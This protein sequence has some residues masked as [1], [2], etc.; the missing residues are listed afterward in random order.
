MDPISA[1]LFNLIVGVVLSG[2][3]ALISAAFAPKPP[4]PTQRARGFRGQVQTGGKVPQS[5]L[6]GTIGSPGKLEY[7]NTWG[8][9]GETPNAYLVDVV[10]FGDLPIAGFTGLF[11]NGE[12]VSIPTTG[13]VT[14]G[15]PVA[16]KAGKLWWEFFDG[17]QTTANTYLTGKFGSDPDR[18]W[19]SDM[20][21]RGVPCLTLTALVD[22]AVW[23]GFPT[24]MGVFQ[25]IK[26]FDPRES[27][28]AGG[29]GSQVWG[30]PSTYTFSDNN[31]VIIYN[32]LRG[33]HDAD[34]NHVWGGHARESQLP[35]DVWAAAMDACDEAVDLAGGGSEKRYRAGREI[36]LD[37]R[38]A[39]VVAEL[40]TG[41]NA[42]IAMAG[43][44]FYIL[45]GVPESADFSFTDADVIVS[46]ETT[47]EPFPN[48]DQIVNGATASYIE[49]SQAWESKETAPYYRSDLE[50]EDDDRRRVVGLDL[51]T[52]FSGTQAQRVL[53]ATVE[54]SRRFVRHVVPLHPQFGQYRPLQVASWTSDANDYTAKLFLVTARTEAPNGNVVVGLQELDPTDFDWDETLDE[55]P[56]SFA[57]LTPI[58]PPAQ[59]M[60]GFAVSPYTFPG[61]AGEP[62]R[63]GILLE[64]TGAMP[65]IR[66]VLF[67]VREDFGDGNTVAQGEI[68]YD[69]DNASAAQPIGGIWTLGNTDY[70]VRAR[71]LPPDGS[72]RTTEWSAW[73]GVTT[74]DVG[75]VPADL[76]AS[77]RAFNDLMA[78]S[79]QNL[80]ETVQLISALGASQDA[81]N[82]SDRL[83]VL[84][85]IAL[86]TA[87]Y[88]KAILLAN[89]VDG[90][91]LADALEAVEA[92]SGDVTA[93]LLTRMTAFASPGGGWVRY[94]IQ[95]RAAFANSFPA[96]A[97][98]YWEVK[99][100]GTS[101]IVHQ[102]SEH[103]FLD[104]LGNVAAMFTG[105]GASF[106]TAYIKDLTADN[107]TAAKLD[108][109]EILQNG[110][111]I[112]ELIAANAVTKTFNGA[113]SSFT[114]ISNSPETTFFTLNVTPLGGEMVVSFTCL[115]KANTGAGTLN[116]ARVRVFRDSTLLKTID[117]I[118][119]SSGG[120]AVVSC[121]FV[122]ASPGTSAC[123]YTL[124]GLNN[125]VT[126]QTG[127]F[128]DSEMVLTNLLDR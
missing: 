124:R 4:E 120:T 3:S 6:V 87:A 89:G 119:I 22:E 57:P 72:G 128:G 62:R 42:R 54:E 36:F 118:F 127:N 25:G 40:L 109:A 63:P 65:D 121:S 107:I 45:V 21:G 56:L 68:T 73:L 117:G 103:Y 88:T 60:A 86:G 59:A 83:Y 24:Y 100:D 28:A 98:T 17:A 19:L 32:I 16:D 80:N 43:G 125:V 46:D 85:K 113:N 35:Y 76:D 111:T 41:A 18:P 38:P 58:L 123:S 70:E 44:V 5:F 93:G 104:N 96:T 77:L 50:A 108:A 82:Y 78:V 114:L 92:A 31:A 15:Y 13:H 91:T 122:D 9:S 71:F 112:R 2:A 47:L 52:T 20:I 34:G 30:T 10:S 8:T 95:A 55:Q 75:I 94:G 81:A 64:Y 1:I 51:P 110:S 53:K 106:N 29:S 69:A 116:S 37:E 102:A 48:L 27:T 33:I 26:L 7:R 115:I 23:P 49:P 84:N 14:Q 79:I 66:A 74:P 126:A 105:D 97:S 90:S 67:E 11:V 39:D 12:A 101:R 61:S 99:A